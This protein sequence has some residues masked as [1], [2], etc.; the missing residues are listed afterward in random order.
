MGSES[1]TGVRTPYDL[2]SIGHFPPQRW[3]EKRGYFPVVV[4]TLIQRR[5][6]VSTFTAVYL[7]EANPDGCEF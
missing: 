6:R 2:G 1:T 3:G 7:L 5:T 4:H